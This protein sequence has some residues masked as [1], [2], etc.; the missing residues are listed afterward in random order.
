M[1]VKF[2][3]MHMTMLLCMIL[4]NKFM[5]LNP[6][7]VQDSSMMGLGQRI[8]P[9]PPQSKWVGNGPQGY[10][11]R[12]NR[13]ERPGRTVSVCNLVGGLEHDFYVPI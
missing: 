12:P 1:I 2:G 4:F 9:F 7:I 11:A 6:L 10:A 5:I 13:T 8:C 3:L